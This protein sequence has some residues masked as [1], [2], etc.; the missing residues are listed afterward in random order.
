[1]K[2]QVTQDHIKNGV[3]GNCTKDPVALALLDAGFIAPWVSPTRIKYTDKEFGY[4][5]EVDV[6]EN[7]MDFL[8]RF[9]NE[10]PVSS[11]NFEVEE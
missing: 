7:V 6:P 10:L 2:I 8:F 3:R 9:D 4:R 1:M 11:F 5:H